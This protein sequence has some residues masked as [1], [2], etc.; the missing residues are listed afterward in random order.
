MIW[1]ASLLGRCMAEQEHF[2]LMTFST[3]SPVSQ[4]GAGSNQA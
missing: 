4:E 2:I 1:I 3:Y